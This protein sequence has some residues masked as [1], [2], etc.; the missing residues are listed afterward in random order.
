MNS[1]GIVEIEVENVINN[2]NFDGKDEEV[3]EEQ[4]LNCIETVASTSNIEKIANPPK[5]IT[6]KDN[7]TISDS[8]VVLGKVNDDILVDQSS[9]DLYGGVMD[10]LNLQE[11][12]P[13]D[14]ALFP[15]L[16]TNKNLKQNILLFGPCKPDINFPI[17]SDG[18]RFST[19]YYYLTTKSGTK[20]PRLWLCYSVRLDKSYCETCWLF[21]DRGYSKFK[22]DWIDGINDWNHLSQCIQ[23]HECSIQHLD[24]TKLRS[25][26][27]KTH[28]IDAELEKQYSDEA[29]KWRNIL[30]RLIKIILYLTA[31]NSALR[32]NEGSKQLNNPTEG[33]FLRTVYLLAEF[34]PF[35]KSVLEDKNQK[36]KYLSASIQNELIDILSTD[37]RRTICN[38]IR[39]SIFFSVILDSTQDI[40]KEDQV[41]LVIRYTK[42]NHEQKQIVIKESFLGFFLLKHHNSISYA[43]LLKNTLLKFDLNILKCRGQGYDG[44]AVMSCSLTGVQKRIRDIVPNATFIH[45]CSHNINLIICDAAKSTRKVLSFFETVQDIYNFFSSSSLRWKQL[46]FGEDKGLKI[47]NVTIKKL[48]PTRWEARHNAIFSLKQRFSDIL[49][50]LSNIQLTSDKSDEIHMAKILQNKLGSAEFILILCIWEPILGSLQI[51]SKTLQSVH[52]SL[53]KASIQL[54]KATES[55]EKMR[56]EYEKITDN[57]RKLCE[58]WNIPFKFDKKRQRFA[59]RHFDEVDSDYRL[60]VMEDNFKVNVFYPVIDTTL[61]QL[62]ERFKGMQMVCED[63]SILI[64]QTLVEMS[65]K[66]LIKSAYD[67]IIKYKDDI[68]SDFTRQIISL[69][70]YLSSTYQENSLKK[71]TVQ[72][73]GDIIIK[74]D[75][76]SI[77]PDV[78]T[79]IIIFMTIPVTSASAE[80]SFSKL[81]LIKNYL[82]N[83]IGQDRLSNIAILNIERLQAENINVDKIIEDFANLKARKK[84]FLR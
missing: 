62:R 77:F 1:R 11:D 84:N 37:L 78:F 47:K 58:T 26:C 14:K 73:L 49:R 67:F 9:A 45:C 5:I 28:T 33:N 2:N 38:E 72:H 24:A 74:D 34:D 15:E 56:Q 75:L 70:A 35:L 82:R 3:E 48:C 32:G 83:S 12:F 63:F 13:T 57:A 71:M 25:I 8:H 46:A 39:N 18:K 52:L 69:K 81:K 44:A 7:K 27:A 23:R 21:A 16:I 31:G 42:V 76:T 50:V 41:S 36:I 40:T 61:M 59:V 80:R 65:E 79:G 10:L 19:S 51:V 20:I 4:I 43:D 17:N 6:V 29:M 60:T 53:N 54:Q 68:S 30:K 22:S 64:P 66:L 55:I